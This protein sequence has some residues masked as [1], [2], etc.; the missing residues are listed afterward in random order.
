MN[1]PAMQQRQ[2]ADNREYHGKHKPERFFGTHFRAVRGLDR[3]VGTYFLHNHGFT[4]RTAKSPCLSKSAS[5]PLKRRWHFFPPAL[6]GDKGGRIFVI[7]LRFFA[8]LAALALTQ[9]VAVKDKAMDKNNGSQDPKIVDLGK[10]REEQARNQ[11]PP[12][13]PLINLPPVTK[14]LL[15]SF[16]LIHLVLNYAVAPETHYDAYMTFGFVPGYYTGAAA[17]GQS[18][19]LFTGPL[20]YMFLHGS[21]LHI[22]MNGVMLMAFGAGMERWM[23]GRRMFVFFYLCCLTA[24]LIHFAFSLQSD[25]PVIGASGG[26]SGLFAAAIVM[27][28]QRGQM[29][30]D[31]RSLWAFALIWIL[32]SVAFGLM[33]GPGGEQIAWQAHIGGFLAGF[34]FLKPVMTWFR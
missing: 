22:I 30:G 17:P 5:P 31:P 10:V 19:A 34:I 3:F 18:W 20:A 25:D 21:W 26:L 28:Q 11:K 8:P 6:R 12:H 9:R 7:S 1:A 23:G 27:L 29:G 24:V 15:A 13:E 4:A 16:V 33:G 32:T 14:Y 2:A